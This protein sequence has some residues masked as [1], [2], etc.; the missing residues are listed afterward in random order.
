MGGEY[1]RE[2]PSDA[3]FQFVILS[4][5][6]TLCGRIKFFIEIDSLFPKLINVETKIYISPPE[7]IFSYLNPFM[8]WKLVMC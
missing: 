5:S 3:T 1:N 2:I 7:D 6:I 8:T 4:I